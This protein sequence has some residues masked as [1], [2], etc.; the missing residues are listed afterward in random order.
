MSRPSVQV[1]VLR[2]FVVED[3]PAI[4]Q[5]LALLLDGTEGFACAGTAGSAE[6]AMAAST[7]PPPDVVLL[8]IGL[9]G[10]SGIEVLPALRARWPAADVLMLTVLDDERN[11][12]DA[13]CGGATGYL[14]KATPPAEILTAIQE[15]HAGGA[16]MSA[17][18]ARRVLGRLRETASAPRAAPSSDPLSDRERE[19]LDRLAQGKTYGQIAAELFVSRNTVAFHV[20][21]IYAKLHATTRAELLGHAL[22]R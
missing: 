3:Q 17:S 5:M 4:R 7:E 6:A 10:R 2:V 19:V 1:P 21:R 8:D 16:P 11:V 20:K 13:L 18:V 22:G 15:V 12:F 14:L 9:P